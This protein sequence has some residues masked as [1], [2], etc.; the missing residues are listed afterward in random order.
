LLRLV[1]CALSID[2][3]IRDVSGRQGLHIRQTLFVD[4]AR[5]W[6]DEAT[7]IGRGSSLVLSPVLYQSILER[8]APLSTD[9]IRKLRKSP[10]DLDVYAWLVH[11][12][13]HLSKPSSLTWDQLSGQI[14]HSY[15]E[16]RYFRRFFGDSL[17]RVLQVYP[18]ARVNLSEKGLLLLPSKPHIEPRARVGA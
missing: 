3:N 2:E 16:L 15:G 4:E 9:A 10:M 5:L 18:E 13:F 12:L 6:W 14:G 8:S 17:K 7:G 11:R 1:H